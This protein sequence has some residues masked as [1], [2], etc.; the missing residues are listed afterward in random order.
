MC[1]TFLLWHSMEIRPGHISV[2]VLIR[3]V[4]LYSSTFNKNIFMLHLGRLNAIISALFQSSAFK[5]KDVIVSE[6]HFVLR[7]YS[8]FTALS[9]HDFNRSGIR[10]T[11]TSL[12]DDCKSV[13]LIT[14]LKESSACFAKNERCSSYY[15]PQCQQS[16]VNMI[17]CQC[18]QSFGCSWERNFLYVFSTSYFSVSTYIKQW[19]KFLSML[20]FICPFHVCTLGCK[21][22]LTSSGMSVSANAEIVYFNP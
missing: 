10:S 11:I 3:S 20:T 7:G 14:N 18:H 4:W 12:N 1:I 21:H 22:T 13:L 9:F 19:S 5:Y 8:D 6:L 17:N 16:S 15:L 2:S